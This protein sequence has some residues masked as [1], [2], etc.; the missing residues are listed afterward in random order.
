M[1]ST[2]KAAETSRLYLIKILG[3]GRKK[4]Q[5]VYIYVY[6]DIWQKAT[7]SDLVIIYRHTYIVILAIHFIKAMIN[8]FSLYLHICFGTQ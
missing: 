5:C 7:T 8:L 2:V 1:K 6:T 3:G 4:N